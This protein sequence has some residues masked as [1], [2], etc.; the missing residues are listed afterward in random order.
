MKTFLSFLAG[1]ATTFI[2]LFCIGNLSNQD[3]SPYQFFE[4]PEE[5]INDYKIEVFQ[6]L[7]PGYALA[8]PQKRDYTMDISTLTVVLLYSPDEKPFYDN[9]VVLIP[10]G[11]CARQVGVY[12]YV[13]KE[14]I[15]KTVPIVQ[16]MEKETHKGK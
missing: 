2:V 3:S 10:K 6:A 11:Y 4:Q 16:I 13:T 5:C 8:Y 14:Q 9:Q 1:V 15:P 12:K 7:E